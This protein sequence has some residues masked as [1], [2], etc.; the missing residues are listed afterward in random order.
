MEEQGYSLILSNGWTRRI[1]DS[2]WFLFHCQFLRQGKTPKDTNFFPMSWLP[3]SAAVGFWRQYSRRSQI[4]C[5]LFWRYSPRAE[6]KHGLPWR[7]P[8]RQQVC[9]RSSLSK[10]WV[11]LKPCWCQSSYNVFPWVSGVWCWGVWGWAACVVLQ[12]ACA[13]PLRGCSTACRQSWTTWAP[14]RSPCGSSRIW[15]GYEAFPWPSRR[16]FLW[17]RFSR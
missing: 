11:F 10:R 4:T 5:W 12:A 6:A 17:L 2:F 9:S 1:I 7:G 16:V 15:S 8:G 13:S 3:K 14:S